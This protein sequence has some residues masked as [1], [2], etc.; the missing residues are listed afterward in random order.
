M[1]PSLSIVIPAFNEAAST[2]AS[3][4]DA[5]EVGAAHAAAVEVVV[6]DDGSRDDTAAIA[7]AVAAR[8]PR[9]IVLR[10][11][12]NRGIEASMRALY[13]PAPRLPVADVER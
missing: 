1:L 6:C 12:V 2:E 7:G 9:A 11:P 3:V 4:R 5:L 13:A 10:R 8:D